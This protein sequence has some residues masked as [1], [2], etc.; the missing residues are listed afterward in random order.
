M[1]IKQFEKNSLAREAG[2]EIAD[3]V[4]TI[5]GYLVK[6]II[7]YQY[8][9]S[10][11]FLEIE[12]DRDGQPLIFEIEK[13]YD[14]SLGIIFENF[15]Y[16]H[17]G[18]KC[19]FCFVD[20]NPP[21]LRKSLYFKDEDYRLSFLYGNYVTLTNISKKELQR[22]V[23]QRLSPLYVSVHSTNLSVRK[24]MLG[25]KKDDSLMQKIHF[26]TDHQIELHTQ[27]VLCPGI[28]DGSSLL[29]S[30]N[31]L[32]QFFPYLKS[33]AIV[34]VGLTEHRDS[35]YPLTP[36]TAPYSKKLIHQ[37]NEFADSIKKE[38]DDYIVYLADEFYLQANMELPAA[39]RYQEFP[40]IE[41]GVG[42]ARNFIDCFEEQ[43]SRLPHR[44]SQEKTLTFVTG[45]LASSIIQLHIIHRL[46]QIRNLSVSLCTIKNNFF[47][48]SVTVTG[49]LTG[50]DIYS[51]LKDVQLGDKIILPE[52]CLNFEGFFLDNWTPEQLE[53]KLSK[54][55]EFM[56]NDFVSLIEKI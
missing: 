39:E 18:N 1:K 53:K 36:V 41:N 55:F 20:Q 50:N 43:S 37:I 15:K 14:E 28:N 29:N 10:E 31:D 7:D 44:I 47:G 34:P 25:I 30:T 42:M 46:N 9:V 52:N 3:D 8:H 17:C 54:P 48:N 22:I 23:K 49:L 11:E 33:I 45:E 6:D 51:Q 13:D 12:V 16:K 35:L 21:Q 26:L 19:I 5:N 24:K 38:M 27:I 56:E 2:F 40:Q 32:K 4:V